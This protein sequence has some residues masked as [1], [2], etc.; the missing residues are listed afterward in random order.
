MVGKPKN[1]GLYEA[2]HEHDGCGIGAV[3]NICGRRDHSIIKYGRQIIVN[4]H[5]RGATGA[6]E[7]TGDGAGILFQIPHEVFCQGRKN[8]IFDSETRRCRMFNWCGVGEVHGCEVEWVKDSCNWKIKELPGN[9]FVLKADLVILATG[10]LHVVP[11]G[12]IKNLGLKLDEKDNIKA[13]NYQISE[14]WVF[15]AGDTVSG[16]SLVVSAISSG[17]GAAA[18][19]QRLTETCPEHSRKG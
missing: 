12:I 8:R 11:E 17:R 16:A 15:A 7:T 19:D 14:P 9:D 6:D 10:F 5:H 18:I 2:R 4:L 1:Q 3:V 13:D